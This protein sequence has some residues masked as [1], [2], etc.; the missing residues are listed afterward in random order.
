M[1]YCDRSSPYC[2]RPLAVDLEDLD[3]DD[4]LGARLVVGGDDLF[5]DAGDRR[6]R[7]HRDAVGGLVRGELRGHRHLRCADDGRQEPHQFDDIRVRDVERP[8]DLRGIRGARLLR[9]RRDDDGRRVDYRVEGAVRRENPGQRLLERQPGQRHRER[10]VLELLVVGDVDPAGGAEKVDDGPQARVGE[11][12][13]Q[14]LVRRRVQQRRLHLPTRLLAQGLDGRGRAGRRRELSQRLLQIGDRD[15]G[16]P[17]RRVQRIRPAVRLQRAAQIARGLPCG[18]RRG[19]R[20]GRL[21]HRPLER[22]P[23]LRPIRVVRHGPPVVLDRGV[24][25]P[26][27]ARRRALSERAAGGAAGAQ[28]RSRQHHD[29]GHPSPRPDVPTAGVP[30]HGFPAARVLTGRL[31]RRRSAP[32]RRRRMRWR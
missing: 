22:N 31:P 23:V 26:G 1:A 24:P 14:R 20:A 8:D 9:I 7:A 10:A 30:R 17:V 6:R 25:L 12:H 19:V 18:R 4:H 28:Q 15:R 29:G 27:P 2:F 11:R 21:P 32:R 13:G 5:D 16:L 3:V